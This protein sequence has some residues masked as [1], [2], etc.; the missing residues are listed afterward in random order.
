[1]SPSRAHPLFEGMKNRK[2]KIIFV[3]LTVET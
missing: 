3:A 1:M 2:C